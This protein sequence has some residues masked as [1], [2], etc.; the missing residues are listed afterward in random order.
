MASKHNSPVA[1][2]TI[3]E[4]GCVD[5]NTRLWISDNTLCT[6]PLCLAA[7]HGQLSAARA[8]LRLGALPTLPQIQKHHANGP[9]THLLPVELA[10]RHKHFEMYTLLRRVEEV[11]VARAIDE[12]G[13]PVLKR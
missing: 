2:R 1:I 8:L 5:V 12:L 9:E 4:V 10:S 3:C 7:T 6:T 11:G 13:S